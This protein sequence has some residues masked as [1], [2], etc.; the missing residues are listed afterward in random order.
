MGIP[1]IQARLRIH[2]NGPPLSKF[3]AQAARIEWIKKG[4]E[5]AETIS[6]KQLVIQ[7]IRKDDHKYD[8]KIFD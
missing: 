3:N 7:R 6:R 2:I 5:Y 1:M 8:C 4:H